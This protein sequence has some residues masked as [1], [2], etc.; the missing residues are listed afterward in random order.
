ME[1][2]RAGIKTTME[3]D[4]AGIKTCKTLQHV[5]SHTYHAGVAGL[6]IML[7]NF[8]LTSKES[9]VEHSLICFLTLFPLLSI[10]RL[11]ILIIHN[12]SLF[13]LCQIVSLAE[14][15]SFLFFC[16]IHPECLAFLYLPSLMPHLFCIFHPQYLTLSVLSYCIDLKYFGKVQ[17]S[18]VILS[19]SPCASSLLYQTFE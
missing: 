6:Q 2:D 8:H 3:I 15:E 16:Y 17:P 9:R 11:P 1:I 7:I 18:S 12:T 4:R 19:T 13:V 14:K 5:L 10:P